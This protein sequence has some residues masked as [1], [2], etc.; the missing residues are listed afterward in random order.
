VVTFDRFAVNSRSLV[1]YDD[2][3]PNA[4]EVTIDGKSLDLNS[5]PASGERSGAWYQSEPI[6]LDAGTHPISAGYG[7]P[8]TPLRVGV[9]ELAPAADSPAPAAGAPPAVTFRQ[10]NP[11]RYV[12]HVQTASAPFFLVFS[13]SYHAGWEAYTEDGPVG[14]SWYEQSALLTWLFDSSRQSLVA[15]HDLV[16]GFANSWYVD[17]PGSYD[18]VLEF[19]PQRLYEAGV[20]VTIATPLALFALLGMLRL[21]R[22]PSQ[23]G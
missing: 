9:L 20:V 23:G 12:A 6:D 14:Q 5:M 8:T 1:P 13:E 19:A 15:Q 11:T 4:P 16:N 10:V 17:K 7:D 3:S 18:I 22:K 21:R 2:V